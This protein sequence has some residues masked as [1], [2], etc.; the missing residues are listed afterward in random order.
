MLHEREQ[1]DKTNRSFSKRIADSNPIDLVKGAVR[2]ASEDEAVVENSVDHPPTPCESQ[3]HLPS[4]QGQWSTPLGP[5]EEMA[6]IA[7]LVL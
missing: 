4:R 3:P 1:L 2:E 7:H 5:Q 6:P